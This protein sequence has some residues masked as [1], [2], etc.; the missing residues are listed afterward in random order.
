MRRIM[1]MAYVAI[2]ATMLQAQSFTE[3]Q[4][5][6]V[7]AINRAEMHTDY[8]VFTSLQEAT[9]DYCDKDTPYRMSLN[10]TWRFHWVENADQRPSDFYTLRYDDAAWDKIEVPEMWELNGYGDPVY[11]NIGYAWRN[12][13]EH[14]PPYVPTEQNHVGS[15]RRTFEFQDEWEGL[16]IFLNIGAVTSNVY[17]WLNGHFVGYSEDS[18]LGAS[19]DITPYLRKGENLIALQ[20][21]RWCDGT[22]LEDQDLWRMCGIT[23]DVTIEARHR[24]R[25]DDW[26][27]TPSLDEE[28]R[29]G[30]IHVEM[31][32][33]QG[34]DKVT[35]TL[36]DTHGKCMS[37]QEVT[38]RKGLAT[39]TFALENPLLWSAETPHLYK[40][41]AEV[42]G[43]S[44][45]TE[46]IAQRVG[47]RTSEI[48]NGQLL[49]N[50]YPI[51]IKGVNRHEIDTRKGFVMSRERMIEDITLMKKFNI[52]AVRTSH[53]PNTP[54]WYDLCDEYGLYVVDEANVESHGMGYDEKTLAR[55]DAYKKAHLERN[56]RMVKRDRNHASVII[57]SMGNEA[58]M[59]EN[60]EACYHWIKTTDPT[61]PIHYERAVDYRDFTGTHYTDIM[62]PMY[63]S[64]RWCE[65]YLNSH[66][67]RPLIQ[68]EYA[69]AMGNSMGGLKE[70]WDITRQYAQY[71][72]GFIWDFVDQ[73]LARYEK[74]GKVSFLYG[75]DYNDY[76]AS[77]YSF[78]CNGIIAAD[79]TPHAHAYEV[80]H[81]YQ[82]IWTY[83]IDLANGIVEVYNEN[84]FTDLDNYYLEWQ[85]VQD[86]IITHRGRIEH[87]DV[88]PQE[89]KQYRLP[90]ATDDIKTD[91]HEVLLNIAYTHRNK[92]PLLPI[93]HVVAHNQLIIK[94]YNC[95]ASFGM[96][97]SSREIVITRYEK[98]T[99]VEGYDW[100]ITFN[101]N[102]L[103]NG[104]DYGNLSMMPDGST[105]RPNFWRAATENDWGAALHRHFAVWREP[106]LSLQDFDYRVENNQAIITTLHDM[107]DVSAQLHITYTING[108]GEIKVSQRLLT[109]DGV[110]VPN[111]FRYGMRMEM[112]ARYNIVEYYGRGNVENY[113]DRKSCANIGVYRQSVN[114]LYNNHMARPQESGTRS[115]LRY[116]KITD[117]SGAGL[118]IIADTPF[119]A[120]ALPYSI[121]A[122]D[123]SRNDYRRHSGQLQSDEKIHLCF[124]LLQQGVGCINSWG[125]WP[126]EP[127][128]VPY[129]DYTFNFIITPLR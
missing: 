93:D 4:D 11:V 12:N 48:K 73:G 61:R 52:N 6:R 13:F 50:G 69:H 91:A 18:H 108:D 47:V 107:P 87:L 100:V 118:R 76:D 8:K 37:K 97:N 19:F 63:A 102:G 72:G 124:D 99:R 33:T 36:W 25:I 83:P 126:L 54:E 111:M 114:E 5:P 29:N 125:A 104:M 23:R 62:C 117:T 16:D 74:D 122:L 77:D 103:I 14:N 92:Q 41:T 34:V 24:Q 32:L 110:K 57:W 70:Y 71:Q 42:K 39:A 112:N 45:T 127:Y 129:Q 64:P 116:Y 101:R 31:K 105:L 115:D 88:K 120:S 59:G 21:F 82:S 80:K 28:Y 60:F 58:G 94:E 44:G 7:N 66:P 1:A 106:S 30:N 68:C 27:I 53:Y 65:R 20:V 86:G 46:V 55:V 10:G 67:T 22:Y 9:G 128:R 84:F 43:R 109:T 121:E 15:Y 35:V 123:L 2:G 40:I 51:L 81:Q 75:G 90:Y 79:R 96:N 17:V 38:P 98:S 56:Q 89:R 113:S 85:L 26:H 95:K 78:N 119:S 49:I 3:W